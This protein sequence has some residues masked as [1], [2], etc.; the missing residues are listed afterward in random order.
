MDQK[1]IFCDACS[2]THLEGRYHLEPDLDLCRDCAE[3]AKKST[4]SVPYMRKFV[5]AVRKLMTE[6]EMDAMDADPDDSIPLALS[7]QR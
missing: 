7:Q 6:E 5:E 1:N 4:L 3:N 2:R